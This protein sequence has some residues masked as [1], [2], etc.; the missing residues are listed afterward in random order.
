MREILTKIRKFDFTLS[1]VFYILF[2]VLTFLLLRV[3][4]KPIGPNGSL[5]GLATINQ[6]VFD[7]LGTSIIWYNI[8]EFLGVI[9][10]LYMI[11]FAVYGFVQL[12]NRHKL[13]KVDLDLY[14]LGL[15]YILII[16]CYIV[17]ETFIINFRPVLISL[18]DGMEASYPSSHTM[19]VV[20]VMATGAMQFYARFKNK[21]LRIVSVVVSIAILVATVIGRMLSGVHWFTDIFGALLLSATLIT[22]YCSLVKRVKKNKS[23]KRKTK[24]K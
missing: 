23:R 8:T 22:F 1:I 7:C 3:D 16:L 11:G 17:F 5:V 20:C 4:L 24:R 21:I 10:I 2:M 12:L 15:L 18:E 9:A 14:I 13:K 6:F 19:L